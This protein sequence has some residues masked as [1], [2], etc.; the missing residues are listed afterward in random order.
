MEKRSIRLRRAQVRRLL[1]LMRKSRDGGLRM[2]I[3]I[4]L[5]WSRGW[6]SPRIAEALHCAMSTVLRV[7][8]RFLEEREGGLADRRED[9]G[10]RKVTEEL[11]GGLLEL[12]LSC[13]QEHGYA[14]PTWTQEL[15]GAVLEERFGIRLS[16]STVSRMLARL[17]AR[18]GR[19]RPVVICP[20]PRQKRL[21]RLRYLRDLQAQAQ[22]GEIWLYADEVDI[23]LNPKM[24]YDW[25]LRGI[26]KDVVTPGNNRKRYIA[27]A[28]NPKTNHLVWVEGERKRSDLFIAL[29]R[30]VM[31]AYRG[32]FR[33]HI[34][35]DNFSIHTS[36]RST[37]ALAAYGNKLRLHFLPP[38]CQGANRIERL[39]K[40]LHD[41]V[42]R[43]HRCHSIDELM[44]EAHHYLSC[45][46]SAREKINEQKQQNAA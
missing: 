30:A 29:A 14:R 44:S 31:S 32:A 9:N 45:R 38:F 13:P 42:T 33:V 2:R 40:D 15:L 25:M 46:T 6:R 36:R 21:R 12:L 26:Q 4:V 10:E 37:L 1:R 11:L 16:R 19:G 22:P 41:N 27:G 7:V 23:D 35:V 8:D 34:I 20:W 18:K 5:H 24:G 17:G 3:E 28:L 43:N 39:W